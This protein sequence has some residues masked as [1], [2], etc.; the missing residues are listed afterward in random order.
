MATI[1]VDS[2]PSEKAAVKAEITPFLNN[3]IQQLDSATAVFS[4]IGSGGISREDRGDVKKLIIALV[5]DIAFTLRAVF[6]VLPLKGKRTPFHPTFSDI[7][8]A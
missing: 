4:Q 6:G 2:T 5:K 1:S 8:S 3:I 7:E